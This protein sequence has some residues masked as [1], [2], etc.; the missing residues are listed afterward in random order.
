RT[1]LHLLWKIE[2]RSEVLRNFSGKRNDGFSAGLQIQAANF[3]VLVVDDFF[4]S[5][6]ERVAGKQVAR[7]NSFLIVARDGIANPVI[8][9]SVE[10]AK[11]QS[12]F[13]FMP[14]DIQQELPVWRQPWPHGA[15]GLLDDGVFLAGLAIFAFD[16]PKRKHRIIRKISATLRV[17]KIFPVAGRNHAHDTGAVLAFGGGCGLRFGDL[18]TGAAV[19]VVHP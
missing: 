2:F 10:V 14:S 16:L 3:P 5:R 1:L 4:S 13:S 12:A 8:F 9:A 15:A 19:H 11:T 17:V 18:N 6:K 7:K